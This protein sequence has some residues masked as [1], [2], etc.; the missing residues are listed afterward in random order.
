M[1]AAKIALLLLPSNVKI[2]QV[3]K[4][5]LLESN[6]NFNYVFLKVESDLL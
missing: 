6:Q 4:E 5:R 2:K 1:V 3:F